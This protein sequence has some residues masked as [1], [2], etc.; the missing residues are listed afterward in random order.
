MLFE[1]GCERILRYAEDKSKKSSYNH[2]LWNR[3]MH[4]LHMKH[5]IFNLPD[6]H[7]ASGIGVHR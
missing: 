4:R 1:W 2:G 7:L 3:L 6:N 5:Q